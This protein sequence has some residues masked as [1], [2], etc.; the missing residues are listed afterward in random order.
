MKIIINEN[1]YD[2]SERN[3]SDHFNERILTRLNAMDLSDDDIHSINSNYDEFQSY[4]NEFPNGNFAIKIADVFPNENSDQFRNTYG[5]TYFEFTDFNGNTF[6]GNE[7][8]IIVK[9]KNITT[10]LIRKKSYTKGRAAEKF[11][12]KKAFYDLNQFETFLDSQYG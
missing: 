7:V 11:K 1:I 8:W 6:Q 9:N 3:R 12:I 4:Q 2:Q 10:L 5:E